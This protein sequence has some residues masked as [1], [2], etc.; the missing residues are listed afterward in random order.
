MLVKVVTF[1]GKTINIDIEPSETIMDLKLKIFDKEEYIPRGLLGAGRRL[2][3]GRTL[4][5]YN[6]QN[7]SEIRM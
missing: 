2:E 5:H 3:D 6:I 4:S 1:F 7:G